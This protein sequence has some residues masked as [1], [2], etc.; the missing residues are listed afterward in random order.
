[1]NLKLGRIETLLNEI[2][3]KR[4]AAFAVLLDPDSH[5]PKEFAENAQRAVDGGA[6]L[7][8]IGG[9]FMGNAGFTKMVSDLKEQ[10]KV[11][12]ILFPGGAGQV[13]KG[14]DAILFTTLVSG[15]NS[16]YLIEQQITGGVF[17]KAYGL[18]ALPTAY[19]LID[20]GQTTAVQYIS[21]TTPIPADKPKLTAVTAVASELMG[22]RWMYLEAGSGAKNPVP[23]EHIMMVNAATGLNIIVGGGL[24]DVSMIKS[25]VKAG[26]KM[27]VTG[28]VWEKCKD[29]EKI[30]EFAQAIHYKES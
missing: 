7:L 22:M 8:L 29:I 10:V 14:P 25:R 5:G 30:K 13:Q 16:Q 20:G 3:E 17:V 24:T 23:V 9:S 19:C 12:V 27:I 4:G 26:A 2:A 11:P 15:R 18:E 6:D 21:N 28:N 1:M